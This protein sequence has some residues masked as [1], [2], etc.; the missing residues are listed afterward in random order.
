MFTKCNFALYPKKMKMVTRDH[1][2]LLL[3][4]LARLAHIVI[5]C[6]IYLR[7]TLRFTSPYLQLIFFSHCPSTSF[8]LCVVFINVKSKIGFFFSVPSDI[9][10]HY[11]T[12]WSYYSRFCVTSKR[13]FLLI[14]LLIFVLEKK[15]VDFCRKLEIDII[16]TKQ[17]LVC[18]NDI[19]VK[20]ETCPHLLSTEFQ[21]NMLSFWRLFF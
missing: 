12:I 15:A 14:F 5:L 20:R 18:T 13:N 1:S 3:L 6:S 8:T 19:S 4:S 16:N 17:L 2:Y 21:L 11:V 10:G 7:A 9:L